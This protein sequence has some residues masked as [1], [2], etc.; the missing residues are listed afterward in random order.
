MDLSDRTLL[1][2]TRWRPKFVPV[3]HIQRVCAIGTEKDR[4]EILKTVTQRKPEN[5]KERATLV[6]LA[7]H[8]KV[9]GVLF[10]DALG[11]FER[12]KWH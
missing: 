9:G 11:A 12:Q 5:E 3:G 2:M 6:W 8:Y 4:S 7:L 10:L 1:A